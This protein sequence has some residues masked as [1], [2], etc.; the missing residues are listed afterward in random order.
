MQQKKAKP[1]YNVLNPEH[2]I[3]IAIYCRVSTEEQVLHGYSLA[4]QEDALVSY[5]KENGL[6]IVKIYRD[7]GFSARKP[8]MKRKVMLELLEDVKAGLIDRILFVKLDRWTRNVSE[9]HSVQQILDRHNVTWQAILEDYNTITAD[10][11]LKL[12]IMLSVAEN[13]ADRTSERIRF[14]RNSRIQKGEA[15]FASRLCPSATR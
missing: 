4:A 8:I 14:T 10:G 2:V 3:R 13:E 9:F 11:R 15:P 12:N 1:P 6:K 5:A 7:E